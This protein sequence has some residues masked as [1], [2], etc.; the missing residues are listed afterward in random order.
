MGNSDNLFRMEDYLVEAIAKEYG[1]KYIPPKH[2]AG[3]VL[4]IV[5]N[6]KGA[7]AA[8]QTYSELKKTSP[9]DYAFDEGDLNQ[10]GYDLLQ[11]NKSSEALEAF[12]LNVEEYPKSWNAYDSLGEAYMGAGQTDLAIQNYEKSLELNPKNKGGAAML[13]KLKNQKK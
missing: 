6:T 4:L 2:F 5:S 9:S 12:K 10:F 7:P 1:W 8:I 11:A 3:N 13:E